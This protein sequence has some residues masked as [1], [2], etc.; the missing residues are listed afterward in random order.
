MSTNDPAVT[1]N[2]EGWLSAAA[3]PAPHAT[4][5]EYWNARGF[6]IIGRISRNDDHEIVCWRPAPGKPAAWSTWMADLANKNQ[7][8]SA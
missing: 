6:C 1:A 5:I 2:P 8:M 3:H 4:T 7:G